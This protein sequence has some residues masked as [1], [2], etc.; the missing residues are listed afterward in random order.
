MVSCDQIKSALIVWKSTEDNFL[1]LISPG[2]LSPDAKKEVAIPNATVLTHDF[3][4]FP[5]ARHA[6]VPRHTMLT[7][8]QKKEFLEARKLE[9]SQLPSIKASDPI[10]MYFG[11]PLD[12]IIRIERPGW[13]VYRVVTS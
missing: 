8:D 6:M 9:S 5:V 4:M 12:A 1:T 7:E 2:K 13:D 10:S 11:Y 3:L